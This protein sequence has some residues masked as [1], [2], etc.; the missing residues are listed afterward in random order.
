M[1]TTSSSPSL[2]LSLSLLSPLSLSLSL[3]HT[4]FLSIQFEFSSTNTGCPKTLTRS[5]GISCINK[6]Y[7]GRRKKGGRFGRN[8]PQKGGGGPGSDHEFWLEN[9]R[10][11]FLLSFNPEAFKTCRNT[12]KHINLWVLPCSVVVKLTFCH[13]KILAGMF[14]T[15]WYIICIG[16]DGMYHDFTI[17]HFLST[18]FFLNLWI[19]MYV[20][21][22]SSMYMIC[23]VFQ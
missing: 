15:F 8:V 19:Q 22:V 7:K 3:T 12:I 4:H 20:L 23:Y 14:P 1:L 21:I 11:M 16:L 17:T 5:T 6:W 2:S 10:F 13:L 18:L 9:Y